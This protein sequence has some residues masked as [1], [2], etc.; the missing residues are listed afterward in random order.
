MVNKNIKPET[1]DPPLAGLRVVEITSGPMRLVGRYLADLGAEVTR[2]CD[3]KPDELTAGDRYI[4]DHSLE[5]ITLDRGK[6]LIRFQD[7]DAEKQQDLLQQMGTIDL[8]IEDISTSSA[9]HWLDLAALRQG[10]PR[11]II[12]SISNF[13]LSGSY[14]GWQATEPVLQALSGSLSRSGLPGRA[15][16]LP[17]DGVALRCAA[18]QAGLVALQ[19]VYA[20]QTT[21]L[22]DWLDFSILDGAAQVLDPGFGVVGSATGGSLSGGVGRG[23]PDVRFRYPII[24]CADGFVR[25]CL[26]APRQW[27]GMFTWMGSPPEFADPTFQS[28]KT[29]FESPALIPAITR[30]FAGKTRADLEREGSAAGVPITAVLA[31]EEAIATAQNQAREVFETVP[32]GDG[33]HVTLPKTCLRIDGQ[34]ATGPCPDT[35]T[36]A[37]PFHSGLPVP[38]IDMTAP[39]VL[40][41]LAGLKV[42][43]LGVIVVGAETGRLFADAGAD[44]VKVENPAFP[45][46]L[47]QTL[48]GSAISNSFAAGQRNKRSLS[49]DLRH[50][51]GKDIFLELV[52]VSDVLLFNF[53]PGA[54]EALGLGQ[55]VLLQ[56][57]PQLV[58]V[59]SSAFGE[60]G[61]ASARLGYGPLVRAAAGITSGWSYPD[62]PESF[63]DA[64]TVYPD[65]VAARLGALVAIA[66]LIRRHRTGRGGASSL[67]Q[68]EVILDHMGVEIAIAKL[69]ASGHEVK[70]RE[71]DAPWGVFPCAGDDE[72]CVVT[73]RGDQDWQALAPLIGL[74]HDQGL[75]H[76]AGRI[77]HRDTIETALKRWLA[78][79]SPTQAMTALQAAGIPAAAMLRVSEMLTFPYFV[80]RDFFRE[81]HHPALAVSLPMETRPARS[82]NWMDAEQ[83]PAPF[84]GEQSADILHEWLGMPGKEIETLIKAGIVSVPV[85][86]KAA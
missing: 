5:S 67:A 64:L 57:N 3:A 43:D 71:G 29:R 60:T 41:P 38:A 85:G 20:R 18:A 73:V 84:M 4:A 34:R 24:P 61:P 86:H 55:D 11:L 59:E 15:P 39:Q 21:G 44:V 27:Q 79:Q 68:L 23:R 50:P 10:H 45:D 66:L 80:E 26:L 76:R 8:L 77:M 81:T 33:Y 72:W 69:A 40:R 51:D 83:K 16:L 32:V 36:K 47:R 49:L 58:I 7:F 28:L 42:L 6:R 22:G 82:A 14:A 17:P 78:T 46:G 48:D 35:E 2:V 53:K 30:F 19:A 37:T 65:H 70:G 12:L 74:E 62:D 13:G 63:S 75:A 52:K 25:V 54:L 56:A 31:P 9:G 1:F